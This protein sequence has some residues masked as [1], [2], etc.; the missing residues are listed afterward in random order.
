MEWHYAQP[1][2]SKRGQSQISS[3]WIGI[4]N[5]LRVRSGQSEVSITL[6]AD[7]LALRTCWEFEVVKARSVSNQEQ[8][9]WYC[10]PAESSNWSKRGQY[11]ISS[12]WNGITHNLRI[13]IGQSEVSTA[14]A[15]H[16]MALRTH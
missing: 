3:R 8:M 14:L 2:S 10:A 16:G 9:E 13:Q 12:G 15:A 6:A 1:E 5:I 7:G 4:T 11:R